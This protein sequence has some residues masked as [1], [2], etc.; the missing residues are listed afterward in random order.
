MTRQRQIDDNQDDLGRSVNNPRDRIG[1]RA[2][3]DKVRETSRALQHPSKPETKTAPHDNM[4]G[5]FKHRSKPH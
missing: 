2:T 1:D 5:G 4:S 3:I